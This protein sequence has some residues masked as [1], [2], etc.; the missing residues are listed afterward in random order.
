VASVSRSALSKLLGLSPNRVSELKEVGVID[1]LAGGVYDPLDSARR[2]IEYRRTKATERNQSGDR[3]VLE[4]KLR[5]Y[6]SNLQKDRNRLARLMEDA[7]TIEDVRKDYNFIR[8]VVLR[9]SAK[10]PAQLA[11]VTSGIKNPA[12][13]AEAIQVVVRACLTSI[14]EALDVHTHSTE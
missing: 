9:E 10:L 11:E 12:E 4:A 8:D 2:Y 5:K 1:V 14:S 13:C 3:E 6:R 7:L